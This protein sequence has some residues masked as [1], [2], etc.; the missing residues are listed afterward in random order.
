MRAPLTSVLR[1]FDCTSCTELAYR[2]TSQNGHLS[3]LHSTALFAPRHQN[4]YN[5][6]LYNAEASVMR[7]PGPTP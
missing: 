5:S 2:R 3:I 1:R 4:S 6:Y 7:T